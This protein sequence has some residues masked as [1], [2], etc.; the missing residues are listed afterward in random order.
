MS[1][2]ELTGRIT[3]NGKLE[4]ELPEGLPPGEVQVTIELPQQEQ[5]TSSDEQ[6]ITQDELDELM[7]VEPMTGAEIVKAGL[8]GG[9][10]DEGITDSVAWVE[11][12]RRKHGRKLVW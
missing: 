10:A 9:W 12:Q 5:L 4:L 7:R 3:E 1:S 6:P 8:L 11:E 2:I